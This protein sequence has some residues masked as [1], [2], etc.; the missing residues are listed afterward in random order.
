VKR[1]TF[2]A[3][4]FFAVLVVGFGWSASPS[5]AQDIMPDPT[6]TPA[7]GATPTPTPTVSPTPVTV[8]GT[9]ASA[10]T[11]DQNVPAQAAD[12]NPMTRWSGYGN[13]AWLELDMGAVARVAEVRIAVFRGDTRSN[14]FDLE[15][16]SD[17]TQW[18]P[19]H[20]GVSSA[21]TT[22][23]Q[24][25]AFFHRYARYVRYVGHGSVSNTGETALWNSLN[26][27]QV[28]S[29]Q[30]Q[31]QPR[32]QTLTASTIYDAGA[33][34]LQ[35]SV[36]PGASSYHVYRRQPGTEWT[37]ITSTSMPSFT[38]WGLS[39]G[40]RYCYAVTSLLSNNPSSTES[41]FSNEA[42]AVGSVM[43][44]PPPP[45]PT[46]L[47]A[48]MGTVGCDGF[49]TRPLTLT[50]DASPGA[51]SYGVWKAVA[52]GAFERIATVTATQYS[53]STVSF[54]FYA[55]SASNGTLSSQ[56]SPTVFGTFAIP[57]C[58][59]PMDLT[60]PASGV[61][62]SGHDG[63]V[64]ANVIDRNLQTRWSAEGDGAWL[65]F[66]LGST[67][68]VAT[69]QIA[70]HHGDQRQN[71]FDILVSNDRVTWT[72]TF[73]GL[74]PQLVSGLQTINLADTPG[75]YV[76]YVGHGSTDPDKLNWNSV[77]ELRVFGY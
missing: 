6:S 35:W 36:V 3:V 30:L 29:A 10:S 63:N 28:F 25:Y 62:A 20:S 53:I 37:R 48:E 31:S 64:P 40:V 18:T 16:S 66:D 61:S 15:V 74:S 76:R 33:I 47:R 39:D 2:S 70:V 77:A 19:V 52:G 65:Q 72:S 59:A 5:R 22:N 26:E 43:P 51:T 60:P 50:W 11:S 44:F 7:P 38:N 17:R 13:G 24:S 27:V 41:F 1:S 55:V 4:A 69:A 57:G 58:P 56:R 68:M 75:R 32:P 8:A 67:R 71:R 34:M 46:N 12:G 9:S 45:V 49:V 54:G 14:K 42:C 23:A 73:T 21:M